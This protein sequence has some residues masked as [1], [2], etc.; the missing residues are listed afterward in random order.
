MKWYCWTSLR[1]IGIWYNEEYD[2]DSDDEYLL[3]D[4][5]LILRSIKY[6]IYVPEGG[7]V[8]DF[9]IDMQ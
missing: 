9:K 5:P 3:S 7:I 4:N 1:G 2:W 8:E 6:I